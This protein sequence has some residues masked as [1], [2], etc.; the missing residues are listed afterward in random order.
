MRVHAAAVAV[1]RAA[2]DP[3][4]CSGAGSGCGFARCGTDLEPRPLDLG[5]CMLNKWPWASAAALTDASMTF[6]WRRIFPASSSCSL[7][8]GRALASGVLGRARCLAF[9]RK[10]IV[11]DF[12]SRSRE[13]QRCHAPYRASGSMM[14]PRVPAGCCLD[15]NLNQRSMDLQQ[16][17][18]PVLGRRFGL[19]VMPIDSVTRVTG[20][21]RENAC[22]PADLTQPTSQTMSV[23]MGADLGHLCALQHGDG[24]VNCP[25][26]TGGSG[27]SPRA[28]Q[29]DR[30]AGQ[31]TVTKWGQYVA[32]TTGTAS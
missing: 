25:A 14:C 5:I 3:G 21:A 24:T 11:R 4:D 1:P 26:D 28:V 15:K 30:R 32:R 8:A 12:T 18:Q 29:D 6:S 9:P 2:W 17:V 20:T 27:L 23:I 22:R 13:N 16:P 31:F 10:R 19:E 7:A